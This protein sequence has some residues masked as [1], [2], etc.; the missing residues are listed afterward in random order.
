MNNYES[1]SQEAVILVTSNVLSFLSKNSDGVQ[2]ATVM[3]HLAHLLFCNMEKATLEKVMVNDLYKTILGKTI[4]NILVATVK[5]Y[6]ILTS[7]SDKE[8]SQLVST[9][10]TQ[11]LSTLEGMM[12]C[13]RKSVPPP[14]EK[15][16]VNIPMTNQHA[17]S[18]PM[19]SFNQ[20]YWNE[21]VDKL[22]PFQGSSNGDATVSEA[23]QHVTFLLEPFLEQVSTSVEATI[24]KSKKKKH[25]NV[26]D[27]NALTAGQAIEG[28][29]NVKK[30]GS[31]AFAHCCAGHFHLLKGLETIC[32]GEVLEERQV[33]IVI[34]SSS[35][36]TSSSTASTTTTTKKKGKKKAST[37]AKSSTTTSTQTTVNV[38][39]N[40][41]STL[42]ISIIASRIID[43]IQE[44]GKLCATFPQRNG[45]EEYIASLHN[46]FANVIIPSKRNSKKPSTTSTST[47]TSPSPSKRARKPDI[48]ALALSTIQSILKNHQQCLYNVAEYIA[49]ELISSKKNAT[50]A[51]QLATGP[52][53]SVAGYTYPDTLQHGYVL[54][55]EEEVNTKA[56]SLV[57]AFGCYNPTTFKMIETLIRCSSSAFSDKSDSKI[58]T[59]I[60][61]AFALR[62]SKV[63]YK[64]ESKKVPLEDITVVDAKLSS[65]ALS[66]YNDVVSG[67]V[68]HIKT[69]LRGDSVDKAVKDLN[70]D[71]IREFALNTPLV[72]DLNTF[73]SDLLDENASTMENSME[74][75]G[76]KNGILL[77]IFFRAN[78]EEGI[79]QAT[80]DQVI[81]SVVKTVTSMLDIVR[82]CYTIKTVPSSQNSEKI[83][84]T[85]CITRCTLAADCF[86]AIHKSIEH[87]SYSSSLAIEK[88]VKCVCLR[89]AVRSLVPTSAAK[90]FIGLGEQLETNLV[91]NRLIWDLSK[92]NNSPS[93][94][95]Q[96]SKLEF[97]QWERR[98]W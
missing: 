98:V 92:E 95:R 87:V 56:T 94:S 93:S 44:S 47:A 41:S 19:S 6:S 67:L 49:D 46:F 64:P 13:K 32:A 79:I 77:S 52:E 66:S 58:M 69:S 37:S 84:Q 70:A 23:V 43:I 17:H 73:Y 82:T 12:E 2:E 24:S 59:A 26:L 4:L 42:M 75:K 1:L 25:D 48:S 78:L 21:L 7:S 39:V 83:K 89:S 54:V 34:G 8:Y 55:N 65:F 62:A 5:G 96:G 57:H 61:A 76:W 74:D 18:I 15:Y 86:D 29:V 10:I 16:T 80:K 35:S 90:A 3:I 38:K 31:M 91:R 85:K 88:E 60:A 9:S 72:P 33:E 11:A 97:E 20:F 63:L 53:T 27:L 14:S 51:F 45:M 50:N 68:S 71:L 36:S 30:F 22:N 81:S 28:R 40:V